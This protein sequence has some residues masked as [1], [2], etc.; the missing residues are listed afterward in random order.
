MIAETIDKG[1]YYFIPKSALADSIRAIYFQL[2]IDRKAN[3]D[4]RPIEFYWNSTCNDGSYNL[5]ITPEQIFFS[6]SHDNPNP[7]FLFWVIDI[8]TLQFRQIRNGLQQKSLKGFNDFSKNYGESVT[9]LYDSR[10]KDT[11]KIPDEWTDAILKRHEVHCDS[12]IR[13][14]LERYLSIINGYISNPTKK[15]L[16]PK[17]QMKPKFFSFSIN[18][19]YDWLPVELNSP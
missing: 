9:V 1:D 3:I 19:I 8:D 10:F 5:I 6:S 13:C 12:Q 14:Q 17:T 18:T 15:I 7:N 16:L 11:F 2:K 4:M